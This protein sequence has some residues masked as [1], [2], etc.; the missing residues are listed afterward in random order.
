MKNLLPHR[1]SLVD[2]MPAVMRQG[3]RNTCAA[4]AAVVLAEYRFGAGTRL[5]VQYLFAETAKRER[6]WIVRN[7]AALRSGETPDA[8]FKAAYP[9]QMAELDLVREAAGAGSDEEKSFLDVFESCQ[10][11][12][13]RGQSLRRCL[14]TLAESGVCRNSLWPYDPN[15]VDRAAS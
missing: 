1:V 15:A 13:L 8:A 4:A 11:K 3:T 7:I 5:S 2:H 10:N 14:E 12:R 6:D 9:T